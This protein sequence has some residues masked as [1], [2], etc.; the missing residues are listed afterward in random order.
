MTS[1]SR[2][3]HTEK[4]RRESHR[5]YWKSDFSCLNLVSSHPM[6]LRFSQDIF[7][8]LI[9]P[10]KTPDGHEPCTL[11][12]QPATLHPFLPHHESCVP[13]F[14]Q[15]PYWRNIATQHAAR[16][17]K[18][19]YVLIGFT[20]SINPFFLTTFILSDLGDIPRPML[21]P[22]PTMRPFR[23]GCVTYQGNLPKQSRCPL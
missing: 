7:S 21:M 22:T 15:N 19:N 1:T 12:R 2:H 17:V 16:A 23:Q 20:Q 6:E 9:H 4:S 13:P 8:N 3:R 10:P 18:S 11:C 5:L 14:V